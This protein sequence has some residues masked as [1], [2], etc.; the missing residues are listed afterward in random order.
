MPGV[1]TTCAKCGAEYSWNTDFQDYPDCPNCGYNGMKIA[2]AQRDKCASA[3]KRGDL[4][5]VKQGLR[6]PDVRQSLNAGPLTILHHAVLGNQIEVVKYLLS[7][8]AEPDRT[9]PQA[10]NETPLHIAAS[11]GYYQIANV[12]VLR[13]ASIDAKNSE[14][15]T[16]IDIAA[17]DARNALLQ[18]C[19]KKNSLTGDFFV[20]IQDGNVDEV[21]D[22]LKMGI[23]PNE[24]LSDM[25]PP[26]FY[27]ARNKVHGKQMAE[28]LIRQGADV[29]VRGRDG[30]SAIHDAIMI[31]R[32]DIA[33]LLIA[34]GADIDIRD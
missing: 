22:F 33:E 30:I 17:D 14:G 29:N 18:I 25:F 1:I 20:A 12:L 8:G 28:I 11:K 9:Y 24:I 4:A 16:P 34:S 3:A 2:R 27:A 7:E 15:E 23:D 21:T 19:G 10:G 31:G 6:D 5:G 13:G 32:R 26:L